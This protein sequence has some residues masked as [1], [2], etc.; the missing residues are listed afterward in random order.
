MMRTRTVVLVA[1][2]FLALPTV[3]QEQKVVM[4]MQLSG[5]KAETLSSFSWGVS[6]PAVMT[7]DAGTVGK[8]GPGELTFTRPVSQSSGTLLE[9]YISGKRFSNI[10][11]KAKK[12]KNKDNGE[13]YMEVKLV[14]LLVSSW[15][16]S[17]TGDD[18]TESTTLAY[19]GIEYVTIGQ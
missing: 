14:D 6:R 2:A 16:V 5:E 8:S 12:K 4:T 18:A 11:L 9:A 7:G 17:G 10:V 19:G 13:M 1:L 15:R 3:A